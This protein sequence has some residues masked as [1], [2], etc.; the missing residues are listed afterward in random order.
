MHRRR[1][2]LCRRRRRHAS[3]GRSGCSAVRN[4]RPVIARPVRCTAGGNGSCDERGAS[5]VARPGGCY[6]SRLISASVAEIM[7][8]GWLASDTRRLRAGALGPGG[9]R[10]CDV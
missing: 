6:Q 4:S 7:V 10:A 2:H 8:A 1:H 3:A 5:R 9:T